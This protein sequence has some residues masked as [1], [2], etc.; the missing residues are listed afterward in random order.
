[1][2]FI[3][4][5]SCCLQSIQLTHAV[6][7]NA[8]P[9]LHGPS[10]QPWCRSGSDFQN[11]FELFHCWIIGGVFNSCQSASNE[12]GGREGSS[13]PDSGFIYDYPCMVSTCI[14]G[15][16][17]KLLSQCFL[18][19]FSSQCSDPLQN[20]IFFSMQCIWGPLRS[21]ASN[22]CF[23]NSL[24][25]IKIFFWFSDILMI[26]FIINNKISQ[27]LLMLRNIHKCP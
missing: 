26:L 12:H 24:L 27:F 18:E 16:S 5:R 3:V 20:H 15:C 13:V 17:F 25:C 19:V 22:I 6:C 10:L 14:C 2:Q 21:W 11:I 4:Q 8:P 23:Q 7:I 9:Y 1:M